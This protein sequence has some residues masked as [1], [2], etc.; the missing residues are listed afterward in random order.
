MH[1]HHISSAVF[2][3]SKL[4][5]FQK[6]CLS[7]ALTNYTFVCS[8]SLCSVC[9]YLSHCSSEATSCCY[10]L[11]VNVNHPILIGVVTSSSEIEVSAVLC[12][13]PKLIPKFADCLHCDSC[14]FQCCC[15]CHCCSLSLCSVF[16]LLRCG[17]TRLFV[18]APCVSSAL[19]HLPFDTLQLG[20]VALKPFFRS[21]C[22]SE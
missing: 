15:V 17:G 11:A 1:R 10:R 18:C 5:T 7:I 12:F 20:C 8:L 22:L 9:F 19:L 2:S 3:R 4:R 13:S 21:V 16:H 14:V 6:S